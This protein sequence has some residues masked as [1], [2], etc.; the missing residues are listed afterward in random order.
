MCI[1]DSGYRLRNNSFFIIRSNA[2]SN[3]T[4][5]HWTHCYNPIRG[6]LIGLATVHNTVFYTLP[7]SSKECN[8]IWNLAVVVRI[9]DN[10]HYQLVLPA[11]SVRLLSMKSFC[12]LAITWQTSCRLYMLFMSYILTWYITSS[13]LSL[14]IIKLRWL[15]FCFYV[16]HHNIQLL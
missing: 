6:T 4:L 3:W 11:G 7:K 10:L 2:F 5:T 12:W 15:L 9:I 16:Y 13:F 14:Q 8:V 1:R